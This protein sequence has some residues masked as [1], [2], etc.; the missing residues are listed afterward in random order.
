M[1][2]NKNKKD[3]KIIK[4][5]MVWVISFLLALVLGT[6]IFGS[7]EKVVNLEEN[8]YGCYF[9]ENISICPFD[10]SAQEVYAW[11]C[12][13]TQ[14]CKDSDKKEMLRLN[15]GETKELRKNI[16]VTYSSYSFKMTKRGWKYF[17]ISSGF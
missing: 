10:T 4:N 14:Y 15:S 13:G 9:E 7:T 6:F 11:V 12:N 2:K 5:L 16:L 1:T 17:H 8:N 3:K